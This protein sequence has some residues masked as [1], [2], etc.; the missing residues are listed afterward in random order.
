MRLLLDTHVFIWW[1]TDAPLSA[2]ALEAIQD[3]ENEILI[4]AVSL[5]EAEIKAASGKIALNTDLR[6]EAHQNGFTELA[7]RFDHAVG[8]AR[9]PLHHPDPFDRML[10]AQARIE[11]LTIA[12][13]DAAFSAYE[14]E[15]VGS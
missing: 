14:V 7:V 3:P 15:L 9:L 6:A 11:G 12:T 13:R 5:W 4:S 1:V 2:E 8:A 10:I